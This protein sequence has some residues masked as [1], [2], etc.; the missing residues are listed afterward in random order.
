[1]RRFGTR[2]VRQYNRS[3]TPRVCWTEELHR[4]FVEAVD[5]LGG[6]NKATPKQILQLMGVDGLS[7]SHVK[8]HLQ[9]C[10]LFFDC[11]IKTMITI[12]R[13]SGNIWINPNLISAR[14]F[15]VCVFFFFLFSFSTGGNSQ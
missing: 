14:S 5:K 9:V 4:L 12:K 7:I 13:L 11:K 1:M 6:R 10:F 8:S 15:S 2:G 3:Q